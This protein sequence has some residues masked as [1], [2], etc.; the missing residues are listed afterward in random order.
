MRR[1]TVLAAL[2]TTALATAGCLDRSED[3]STPTDSSGPGGTDETDTPTGTDDGGPTTPTTPTGRFEGEPCPGFSGGVDRT[4]CYHA[5]GGESTA[6]WLEPDRELFEPTTGDGEASA[7]AG[8]DAAGDGVETITF[9][10]HNESGGSFGLNPHAWRIERRTADGWEHVAPAEH[11]EPW[12]TLSDGET[13]TWRLSVET[14]PSGNWEHFTT[15][16]ENLDAGVYAFA[17]TGHRGREGGESVEC[18][19]L[20]EVER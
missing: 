7:D 13:Y 17:I 5:L 10:L 12:L 11:V 18:V 2:S 15:L 3:G 16:V 8:G 14:H 6:V 20:F 4:V 9:T 19:A 1:R